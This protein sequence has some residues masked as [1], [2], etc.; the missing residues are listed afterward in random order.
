[1]TLQCRKISF[2]VYKLQEYAYLGFAR[3]TAKVPEIRATDLTGR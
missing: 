3:K 1:M 2:F